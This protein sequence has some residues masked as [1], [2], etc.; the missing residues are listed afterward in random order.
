[1]VSEPDGR[2]AHVRAPLRV[3]MVEDSEDD[4]EL[5]LRELQRY[6][7]DVECRRVQ[8][9][10]DTREALTS[11]TWD[12]V[13]S[14]YSMPSYSATAALADV[15]ALGCSLPFIILSGTI[16][17][18]TAVEALRAGAHDFLVKGHLARLGPAIDRALRDVV[19]KAARRTAEAEAAA[20][21]RA[22]ERAE[23][24]SEA[25]SKFLATMSHELRTPLNAIIGFTEM[26][27]AGLAGPVTAA[28]ASHLG[29]VLA[30]SHDLLDL[31]NE[32]LD[33]A[34]IEAGR[35]C[36]SLEATPLGPA[37]DRVVSLHRSDAHARGT[38]LLTQI[39]NDLP[40]L[41]ADRK[42]V[43]Q[44]IDNLVSNAIKFA[45]ARENTVTI[46]AR[47]S[48]DR[49]EISVSDQGRG[50]RPDD[51]P[52]LFQEFER[53]RD[54]GEQHVQGTGLGLALT[55]RLVELLGGS[56]SAESTWGRGSTFTVTLPAA[57]SIPVRPH[58]PAG[59][60]RITI[61]VV[62]DDL[63]S[64]RLASTVLTQAGYLVIQAGSVDAAESILG[65]QTPGLVLTDIG[66]PGG[67]GETLLGLIRAR[68]SARELPVI[69]T[70]ASAM[71][72]DRERLLARGFDAYL[73]KPIDVRTFRQLVDSFFPVAPP[74]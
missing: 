56:I 15:H 46:S 7:F 57:A 54:D 13:L 14:D 63:R 52:R 20:A 12:L 64:T 38:Q 6:G 23:A 71:P 49:I 37:V 19:E 62:E 50:I 34:T 55:R 26:M 5:T 53:L 59:N 35:L 33:L 65:G 51:L 67:G 69:A 17:E 61:L 16:G 22:K 11:E 42:R 41:W 31:I 25:K 4:A 10:G 30:A 66:L 32:V 70:T 47:S 45:P 48:S 18:E 9:A 73:A 40:L 74:S 8:T 21:L 68:F 44:I 58:E 43:G 24:A 39:P 27:Q 2:T 28:Q 3:L 36:V 1:M 72:G 60:D 29:D